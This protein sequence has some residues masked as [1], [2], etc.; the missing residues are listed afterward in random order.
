MNRFIALLL[1]ASFI[2]AQL[3]AWG[4]KGHQVV[5]DIA[6]SRLTAQT[7]KNVRLLL[8]HETLASVS[9]WADDVRRQ[10][11]ESY[12]WHFVDIPKDA[13]G[14]DDARDCF[15]PQ[16]KNQGAQ[17]DHQNCAVD[18]IQ[19]FR[20]VLA[21]SNATS[22]QRVEALKWLVHF[23]GDIHQPL[24]AIDDS[25]GG[26]DIKLPVFGNP[27]CGDYPCNLHWV[28]DNM[29]IEHTGLS[30]GDYVAREQKLIRAERLDQKAGGTPIDWVNE[31]HLDARK[32]MNHVPPSVDDAYY[33][34]NIQLVNERLA[35]AGLRLASLLNETLGR[36][37]TAQLKRELDANPEAMLPT[38]MTIT[39]GAAKG[40]LL[41]PLNPD[42]PEL[43]Q[44]TADHPISARLSPDGNTL[45]VLT[46][47]FNSV[48]NI[49]AKP[50]PALSNEYVFVYDVRGKEPV[51]RQVLRV[52][53][54]YMGIAWSPDGN[55]FYVSGGSDDNVHVF[56]NR[57]GRWSE[58]AAITLGHKLGLGIYQGEDPKKQPGNKPL[59]AGVAASADGSRLLVANNMN[60]S[61]SLIDTKAWKVVAGLDLRPG[62]NDS[63]LKGVPGGEYPYGV[64]FAGNDR[65]YV[66]SL[67]DR[68]IV[69]L[70]LRQKPAIAARI[71][72]HGQPGKLILNR[73]RTL[74]F[75]VCDNS[76]SVVIVD[77]TKNRVV[78]EIKTAAPAEVLPNKGRF[79]GANPTGLAL[80]PDEK[81]LYVSN[82]GTNSVAVV[83][84]QQDL[85]DSRVV[86]LIPTGWYPNDVA[87]NR[88]GSQLFVLNAKSVPG[89]NPK[90][91]RSDYSTS[92]DRPCALNQQYV[93]QLE[94]G[95][96]AVIP[97]P[98]AA[99]LHTLTE[100][101]ARNNNFIPASPSQSQAATFAFLRE[102]I[103]H[104]I[105]I[106]K[107]NRTYDQ[108]LGDLE[109]GNGD[110]AL[111]LFP[112]RLAPN[113]HDL[114]RRF[115]ILDNFY[116][117]GEVSGVGW[118]WSTA[119]RTTDFVERTI[120]MNYADRGPGYDVE[121]VNRGIN[122][123]AT[124]PHDRIRGE[125]N[126]SDP[127]DLLPGTRDVAA[128]DGPD[129]ESGAGYLW[130]AALRAHLSIRNYGFF[131]NI[132]HYSATAD[133]GPPVPLLHD[134][135]AS[136]TRVA[137][138]TKP[139]L[140]DITDPY[141]R[142]FDMRFPDYWRFKEWEREFDAYVKG[143]NLPALELLRLPHDHFGTF[144]EAIDGVNTVETMMA[145][146]DYAIGLVAEKIAHSKYAGST[147]IFILEDDAQNG[148]DHVDAH[149]S[150]AYVIGPYVKQG[151]VI[152]NHFTT[153]SM[154]RTIEE[155]LA[156]QPL[157]LNDA[158]QQP[159]TDVFSQRQST[160]T[161]S[162]RVPEVL[163][164]TKL[165]L[166]P[167]ATSPSG[168]AVPAMAPSRDAS[169]WA[170][171]TRGFD[172]STEDKIDSAAFNRVLWEGLKGD[173]ATYPAERDGIDRSRHR[174]QLLKQQQT[175]S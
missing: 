47:G 141:F 82:G 108:V 126:D 86:G 81:S 111:T 24:H 37:P 98:D 76:D 172:F 22:L 15:R 68:E 92:S 171:K 155:V 89:P 110:P 95:S 21:D 94:K 18:R 79:K 27:Q 35:L 49:R 59:A 4:A 1:I 106:V 97:R 96:L 167:A 134:P 153:V 45:L 93:Y 109:K 100:Q 83:Q 159:M 170:E 135:A 112:D 136:N 162:A 163:R 78:A 173:K 145:D 117:S 137:F 69:V 52:P 57:T 42:L 139:A 166:S 138:P 144:S 63:T 5:G 75:A 50:V 16:D 8:G 133:G 38:G 107:E 174:K 85:D 72:T 71:K 115:V 48:S 103:K 90:A 29:L 168:A 9:T 11:D 73:A 123:G 67:R 77:T 20:Q 130:D 10:R 120:P 55:R 175:G 99:K 146:N 23:V 66:S 122:V 118:N 105:Y 143:D 87:V 64:V 151:A 148:P 32:I 56:E 102:H 113:H 31:S 131:A 40:T 39:P 2:P 150:V 25:R 127:E 157:G 28:W 17:T 12:D 46:S 116:D 36:I 26:N 61:I 165:P 19:Y 129:D 160:W 51:K 60:D 158:L 84:L 128:P 104:V 62:R 7:K 152:S 169:Y 33:R 119:A 14:F 43:P 74:L 101:V 140:Q 44:L 91:C 6:A 41:L 156:L 53:N 65:A 58:A 114:A 142:S 124:N 147:L 132:A 154:L 161:Y 30:E 13:A 149:R 54:T 121:G 88:D 70:D 164:S 3:F 125:L 80:S 34:G